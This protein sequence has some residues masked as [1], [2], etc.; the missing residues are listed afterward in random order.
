MV[1]LDGLSAALPA[2]AIDISAF[3]VIVE[4]ILSLAIDDVFHDPGSAPL[5]YSLR[6]VSRAV[7]DT[8]DTK[9]ARH[10][11]LDLAVKEI[12]DAEHLAEVNAL[13]AKPHLLLRGE[14]EPEFYRDRHGHDRRTIVAI[15]RG[16]RIH[17]ITE[18][19][20]TGQPIACRPAQRIPG[21]RWG[22]G[23]TAADVAEC[24][25]RLRD[26]HVV[27]TT[28][29]EPNDY[30]PMFR[31]RVLLHALLNHETFE[32][33]S[34]ACPPLGLSTAVWQFDIEHRDHPYNWHL[35]VLTSALRQG[36]RSLVACFPP[37]T[38]YLSDV[39]P[40][41]L[42]PVMDHTLESVTIHVQVAEGFVS[43]LSGCGQ[44]SLN[45]VL[46]CIAARLD[47]HWTLVTHPVLDTV[48]LGWHSPGSGS[49]P[50][51]IR[52]AIRDHV[53]EEEGLR[54]HWAEEDR[55]AD[56]VQRVRVVTADEY[57]LEVGLERYRL[58]TEE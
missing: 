17:T 4:D 10:I 21:M 44:T 6:L 3:P 15:Y 37:S 49:T 53:L 50:E 45:G 20:T 18:N 1:A 5:L 54:D 7:K 41:I 43:Q 55:L 42:M 23:A 16:P 31:D 8:I 57:A 48:Y 22:E 35:Q 47:L 26:T 33:A 58:E 14:E 25:R 12:W 2:V 11:S 34:S 38:N 30:P 28:S 36:A 19:V 46:D 51:R 27:D 32:R 56:A 29:S 9:L 39:G 13:R 40:T 24:L 52:L